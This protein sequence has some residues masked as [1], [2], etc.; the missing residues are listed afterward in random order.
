MPR[1]L[2]YRDDTRVAVRVARAP[3]AKLQSRSLRR[4]IVNMLVDNG[5]SMTLRELDE[6][7][8]FDVRDNTQSLI[9]D[10]WLEVV[11]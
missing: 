5:G 3:R 10:G 9:R 8:G 7:F 6:A 1:P 11:A 4:A 2:T